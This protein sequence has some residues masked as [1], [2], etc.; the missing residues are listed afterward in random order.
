[1]KV[2]VVGGAGYIGSVT[3]DLLLEQGHDVVVLDNLSRGHRGSVDPKAALIVGDM[4]DKQALTK[5]FA[6]KPDAVMHFAALSL[7]GESVQQPALYFH[8]NVSNGLKLLE[9]MLEHDVKHFIFSST[10]A[11]YG[12]PPSVPI[13]ED[14]PLAPT[15][16]YGDSKLAFEKIL[17]SYAP[18]YG[19]SYAS[20]R[21][22]NAAGASA[23]KG[24]DHNPE[25]HLIPVV[26]QVAAGKQEKVSIFG[27]DYPT[28]DGTCVRDYIHVSD[29]AQAHLLSLE[30]ICE[31]GGTHIFNLGSE[32]GFS[33]KQ[34]LDEAR[35]ITG[36]AIP[37]VVGPRRAG[38][39]AALVASSARIR[40]TL[41]WTPRK[42][43]LASIIGDAWNWHQNHPDGYKLD[44]VAHV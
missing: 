3:S 15:N 41:K 13:A 43:D 37:T 42:A 19:L 33:V 32:N 44:K 39:P 18:A 2:L 22:F 27:E 36:H 9:A 31:H 16:P 23:T 25:S 34:V 5:A 8:N 7:V 30:H 12:E 10:A 26:L 28:P 21:Y 29:L 4:G 20:L 11:V 24:E 35:R 14:F 38:D 17:K 1:M 40:T 6:T